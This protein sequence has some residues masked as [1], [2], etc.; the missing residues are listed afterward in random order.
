MSLA[1]L[2]LCLLSARPVLAQ[3][4]WTVTDAANNPLQ[5]SGNG[6][7][8]V[9]TATGG[10]TNTYP[11]DMTA[12]ALAPPYYDPQF[13]WVD[14]SQWL[15]AASSGP[16]SYDPNPLGTPYLYN[17]GTT[18]AP[19]TSV[20]LNAT[21]HNYALDNSYYGSFNPKA[22]PF[23][24]NQYYPDPSV[25]EPIN[26]TVTGRTTGTLWAYWNWMGPN[27]PP[28]H[29]NILLTTNV[30]AS[31]SVGGGGS[32]LSATA[33]A[34]DGD[35]FNETATSDAGVP[36]VVGHHLL[37]VPVSGGVA[38]VSLNGNV[39][40]SA[41]NTVPYGAFGGYYYQNNY[42]GNN[43]TE[44]KSIGSVSATANIDGGNREVHIL[45]PLGTTYHKGANAQPVQN[46]PEPYTGILTDDTV[47]PPVGPVT[48]GSGYTIGY[49]AVAGG[50]WN[51]NSSY[52]WSQG[53]QGANGMGSVYDSASAQG[54]LLSSNL[55]PPF[56]VTYGASS[57]LMGVAR[58]HLSI[59]VTDSGDGA[60]ASDDY[61]LNFHNEY[62][63]ITLTDVGQL[64]PWTRVSPDAV[65][66]PA[67]GP[68][69]L[70][71]NISVSVTA[72]VDPSG[73]VGTAVAAQYG[74]AV[75]AT[76]STAVP[77][78][79]SKWQMGRN[80]HN[81]IEDQAFWEHMTGTVD[82]YE[83]QGYVGQTS[84]SLDKPYNASNPLND[85]SEQ[86]VSSDNPPVN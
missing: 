72:S 13:G 12:A 35:P 15:Q 45:P 14:N 17:G 81:W 8:L 46:Q 85:Y 2:S 53:L 41:T 48:L 57:R 68:F 51:P 76:Y 19:S 50:A 47:V 43:P 54:T 37:R 73:S 40:V 49:Q 59:I 7:S 21:A 84:W 70:P 27:A 23:F 22:P 30:S 82:N 77:R 58:D 28:D 74:V 69:P 25:C 38:A 79:G 4:G 16:H 11:Q 24:T 63:F 52:A 65:S 61:F 6:Y 18:S 26:G 36:S 56:T 10:A 83:R 55:T 66:G 44:A 20:A 29:L 60:T 71:I 31:S 9:G 42:S 33:T 75:G 3:G 78:D 34:S 39:S 86:L 5:P 67:G 80:K 62:D 1:F 64:G 32:G